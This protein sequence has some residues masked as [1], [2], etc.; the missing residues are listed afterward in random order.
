[1]SWFKIDNASR[2]QPSGGSYNDWKAEIA[3]DCRNQ[4][5]YCS[6]HE[7]RFGGIDNFHVDHFRPKSREEF[8]HLS[9]VITNLYLSCPICN[10]FKSDD[11]PSD[12]C[13]EFSKPS[14]ID[15]A[16]VDFS[17]V[18]TVGENHLVSGTTVSS[19]Y[20]VARLFLNRPQMIRERRVRS[21]GLLIQELTA[22]L[23]EQLT[24]LIEQGLSLIHI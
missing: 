16:E 13:P 19:T 24:S 15:P 5:V 7:A 12:P 2:E 6:I 8:A 4:C 9:E 14:Y 23:E 10:R 11:W 17:T 20:V 21:V 1:M 3:R 18:V 22:R